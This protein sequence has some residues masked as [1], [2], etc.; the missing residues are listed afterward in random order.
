MQ[1]RQKRKADL[2]KYTV[3]SLGGGGGGETGFSSVLSVI[4]V[5]Y[6]LEV[7]ILDSE[8]LSSDSCP[9]LVLLGDLLDQV[10]LLGG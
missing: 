1:E 7:F 2:S 3:P 5:W 4:M 10:A 6:L 9:I 8:V